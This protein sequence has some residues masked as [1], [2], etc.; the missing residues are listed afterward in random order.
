MPPTLT[1]EDRKRLLAEVNA[2]AGAS[3]QKLWLPSAQLCVL[4][5]RLPGRT[6]LAVADAPLCLVAIAAQRPTAPESAPRSQATLRRALEGRRFAGA[7]LWIAGD[8]RAPAPALRFDD[9]FLVVEGAL[10]V[11]EATSRKILWASSGAQRRPGGRFPDV[12]EL[13][14]PEAQPVAGRDAVV[15]E[16][17]LREE[18]A[19]VAA[20]RREVVA[21]LR[22]RLQKLKRT[23]AAVEE[24]AARASRAASGRARAELL[25]PLASRIPRGAREARVPDWSRADEEGRP[26]EIAVALDPALSAAEN[27]ARWLRKAKRYAAAEGRIAARK[28]QVSRELAQAQELLTRAEAAQDASQLAAVEAEAPARSRPAARG[29]APRLPYRRFGAEG[30]S[31]ILV[32]RS[33]R[34]NDALTFRV[35]R[36]NDVWLHVRGVQGAHVVIPGAGAAPDART[37]GDASLLAVHFSSARGQDAVEV[38]W[39]RCKHVRKPKGAA[40]GSVIVTQE[41]VVRVRTDEERLQWLLRTEAAPAAS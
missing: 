20:R 32:G 18:Q 31:P 35:A 23:L 22:S 19:G 3:L 28:D 8:R 25:L 24:D 2:L 36:G 6:T 30:A 5:L 1:E 34:D 37:L 4:Q 21:R 41:K 10:L 7:A 11:V 9:R 26:A 39:T 29:D 16:A 38:A 13:Q 12:Q 15:R 17:L 14:L 27:A 40:P 33:A